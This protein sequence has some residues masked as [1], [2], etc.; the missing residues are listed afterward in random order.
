MTDAPLAPSPVPEIGKVTVA[1]VFVA[2]RRGFADFIAAPS[3][4]IFFACFYVFVGIGLTLANVGSF[5]WTLVLSLGFPLVAPFAAVGLYEVSRRIEAEEPLDWREVLGVVSRERDRQIPWIGAILVIVF[6]FWSFF[7][8]MLFALFMGM[9]T[10]TNVS[11]SW[12]AFLTPT[13]LTMMTAQVVVGGATAFFVFSITVVSLPLLLE[14]EIDFVTAMLL[15]M[16]TVARNLP[17][18]LIWAALIAG[19]L[20]L[21]MLPMFLGLLVILPTLGHATWHLYRRA[22]YDPV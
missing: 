8:H 3:F 22:L 11:T 21:G 2:L 4:G 6:L 9:S 10:L 17:V 14:K 19:L 15:S 13:G 5:V 1:E 18:M 12:E 16:R 7:A 20:F